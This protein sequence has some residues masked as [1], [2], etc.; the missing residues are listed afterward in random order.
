MIRSG[1]SATDITRILITHFHGDHCLGL[2]GIIQRISLDRVPHRVDV[3]FPESG[4][5]FFDRLQFAS[6]YDNQAKI[7]PL[8]QT[9]EG[10]LYEDKDLRIVG[11]KLDHGVESWGYRI[12]ESDGVRFLPEKLKEAGITGAE[13]GRLSVEGELMKGGR[14]IRLEDVSV[15]RPGQ[16]F[17]IVM[18][19]RRC[20]AAVA[21]AKDVDLLLI[22]STYL[23]AQATEAGER[24]HL[25]AR[26]AAEIAREAGAKNVVLSHFSQRYPS[27]GVFVEEASAIHGQ[28]TAA[29]DGARV[30]ISRK[31]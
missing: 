10:V 13:V 23:H 1:V 2:P 9:E 8:G 16:S 6:I 30:K 21:L 29:R 11:R 4:R 20:D 3:H 5:T 28:V 7:R 17:A 25:T 19:T 14:R 31:K 18:D 22:E 12:E 15:P 26:Q 27:E 24:G